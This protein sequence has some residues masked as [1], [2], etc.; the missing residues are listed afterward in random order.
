MLNKMKF[1]SILITVKHKTCHKNENYFFKFIILTSQNNTLF[2]LDLQDMILFIIY[3]VFP[4][5]RRITSTCS[6][7]SPY[8]DYHNVIYVL[9]GPPNRN[10][11]AYYSKD[12][13]SKLLTKLIILKTFSAVRASVTEIVE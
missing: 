6:Q 11:S 7:S 3:V 2:K 13:D 1:L 12:N 4:E 9:K 8:I 10:F 5:T